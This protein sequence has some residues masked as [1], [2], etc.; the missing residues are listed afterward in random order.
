MTYTLPEGFVPI[1]DRQALNFLQ[2]V[3]SGREGYT[4]ES[5]RTAPEDEEKCFYANRDG[6][7][8]CI[9]GH[10]LHR[11]APDFFAEVFH[12]ENLGETGLSVFGLEGYLE[13]DSDKLLTEDAVTVLRAAQIVQDT[14]G[15]WGDAFEA[16]E[17]YFAGIDLAPSH[18]NW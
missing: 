8:S 17:R 16:A 2:E 1:N 5:D 13:G 9:V 15:T 10:V 6:S 18:D 4:Y 7:P 12:R 14:G 3:V 11:A